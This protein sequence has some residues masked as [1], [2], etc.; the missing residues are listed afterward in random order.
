MK[1]SDIQQRIVT[2]LTGHE[3]VA[4]A[5]VVTTGKFKVKGGYI[6]TGHYITEDQKRLTGMSD[7]IGQLRD[8]RFFCIETKKPGEE[9]T[10]EQ[11]A[12]LDLVEMNGGVSGWADSVES[13]LWIL[14]AA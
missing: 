6:T 2:V 13:A 1:E 10:E 7:I 3:K 4:W 12:F 14:E 5:M 11:F 9:P 8:G